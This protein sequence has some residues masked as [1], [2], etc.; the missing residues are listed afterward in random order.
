MK[1]LSLSTLAE[2]AGA[3]L[4]AGNGERVATG[5]GIDSRTIQPGELFVAIRGEKQ[6]GHA[7][8]MEAVEKGAIA[9]LVE[10]PVTVKIPHGFSILRVG[11]TPIALQKLAKGY[12]RLLSVRVG[13]SRMGMRM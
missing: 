6:D 10:K 3:E 7:H 4:I 11:N 13:K 9:A 5:V 12:R 1:S 8:V 2:M